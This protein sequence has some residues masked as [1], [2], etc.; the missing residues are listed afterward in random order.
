M[1]TNEYS[2]EH[3]SRNKLKTQR[4]CTR[5]YIKLIQSQL[6]NAF[7][8]KSKSKSLTSEK[9]V[10]VIVHKHEHT[11]THLCKSLSGTGLSSEENHNPGL[12]QSNIDFIFLFFPQRQPR[13]RERLLFLAPI[14]RFL[15]YEHQKSNQQGGGGGENQQ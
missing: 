1:Q 4:C 13:H 5:T 8:T 2:L 15:P 12:P 6:S 14:R 10:A 3:I 7:P 11:Q 9:K